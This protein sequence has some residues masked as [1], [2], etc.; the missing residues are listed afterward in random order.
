[1]AYNCVVLI[2]Q[3][4]DTKSI[5][6][7][8]MNDDGTVKRSALPAIF[9]PEDLNALELALQIKEKFGGHITVITMGLPAASAILRDSLYRG[10]DEAILLT[11]RRCAASD[12]LATSYILC[13]AVKRIDYDVVLCGRQAIDGDT[14]QV[15]PQ[16]AEKLGITQIT[17]V[18][19]LEN[20]DGKTITAR[21]NIGNGWQ[22]VKAALPVL[23]TVVGDA[24][25][26]RVAAAKKMMKYKN[27][28]TPIEV[29]QRIKA[30]NPDG[31]EAE[32]REL[33]E[34][35]CNKLEKSG[36]LIRQLDLDAVEADL[37]WCGQSGSPT[38][39]HRIQSVVLAA[40]ESKEIE[41]SKEAISDMIHELIDDKIIA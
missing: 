15:G 8:A 7:E 21:R 34:H 13:C 11:D 25:D 18:E 16:L 17:Y 27:A 37:S 40:K 28:C 39:V 36:L 38:K 10:A 19:E 24:N 14:A 12:T 4:P 33:V 9:N 20:L 31:D 1:M 3:V 41:P 32:I 26:P 35:R 6:G 5:T 29:E 2:K 23:L 22:R 30:E